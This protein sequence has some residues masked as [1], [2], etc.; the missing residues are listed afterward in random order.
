MDYESFEMTYMSRQMAP[1]LLL[2]AFLRICRRGPADELITSLMLP[3]TKSKQIR[4]M[5]PVTVPIQ[6][7]P[8]MILGPT[9]EARGISLNVS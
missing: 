1:A 4:K 9:T 5:V 3:A 6:T 8:I 2:V 7:Q